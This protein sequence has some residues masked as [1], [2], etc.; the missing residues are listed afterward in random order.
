MGGHRE[1][2]LPEEAKF[3]VMLSGDTFKWKF[4]NV[5]DTGN[6]GKRANWRQPI[7]QREGRHN[8]FINRVGD[9]HAANLGWCTHDM[10]L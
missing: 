7:Q 1:N 4:L 10:S 5:T 2:V 3:I 6:Q 9:K 8:S